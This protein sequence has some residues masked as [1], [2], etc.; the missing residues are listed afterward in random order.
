MGR[1]RAYGQLRRMEGLS[2]HDPRVSYAAPVK[3]LFI[4]VQQGKI[5]NYPPGGWL[6]VFQKV[7]SLRQLLLHWK[8]D[9][10]NKK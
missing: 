2:E 5:E 10:K 7:I 6:T 4:G 1:Y 3:A 8:Y 9:Y